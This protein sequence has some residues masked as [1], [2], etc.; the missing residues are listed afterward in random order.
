KFQ[1]R[2]KGHRTYSYS[3]A[4]GELEVRRGI[5]KGLDA[6]ILKPT[7]IIGP[8]DFKPSYFGR[9][10]LAFAQGKIPALVRGGFDWVDV[11]DVVAGMITAQQN[12]PSGSSYILS[13]H[14]RSV[15]AVADQ[16]ATL[17]GVPAPRIVVP[18]WAA[19]LGLPLMKL[20]ANLQKQEPLYTRVSLDA[21]GSDQSISRD[22]AE[23]ELN[24]IPRPFEETIATAVHWFA[25]NGYLRLPS[26]NLG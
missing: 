8:Y 21:L 18:L 10:I 25:D 12:A 6:V 17:T 22:L 24:F 14:W 3:K 16:V 7:G 1:G 2:S 5:E 11:R 19:Y 26:H 4:A 9:A 15:Q 13:G 23:Q 20:L